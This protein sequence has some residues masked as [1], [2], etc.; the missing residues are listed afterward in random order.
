MYLLLYFTDE[1]TVL[2]Y[3]PAFIEWEYNVKAALESGDLTKGYWTAILM[4]EAVEEFL[5]LF[6][7]LYNKEGCG[8][9]HIP[10]INMDWSSNHAAKADNCLANVAKNFR[11]SWGN[12]YVKKTGERKKCPVGDNADGSQTLTAADLFVGGE[13]HQ[14]GPNMEQYFHFRRGDAPPLSHPDLELKEYIG[15]DKGL[16]QIMWERGYPISTMNMKGNIVSTILRC[17]Y[18]NSVA[19]GIVFVVFYN[20]SFFLVFANTFLFKSDP[21]LHI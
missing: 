4:N 6:F 10:L 9:D 15:H 8:V 17:I 1:A 21:K 16:D 20:E 19:Y 13:T 12:R 14:L 7:F 18:D 2:A 5:D 3:N 11:K